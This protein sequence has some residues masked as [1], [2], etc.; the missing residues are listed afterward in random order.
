M[1]GQQECS[2]GGGSNPTHAWNG[3]QARERNRAAWHTRSTKAR[4]KYMSMYVHHNGGRGSQNVKQNI[5]TEDQGNN[6]I[7]E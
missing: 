5:K 4:P 1:C 6:N 7:Q 3:K 2:G